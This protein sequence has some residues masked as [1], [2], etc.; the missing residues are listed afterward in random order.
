MDV[1]LI[2]KHWRKLSNSALFSSVPASTCSSWGGACPRN[3][4][5]VNQLDYLLRG[6]CWCNKGYMIVG[7]TINY[8]V[9]GHG[10]TL[11]VCPIM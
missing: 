2:E 5:L 6:V 8:V 9:E 3:P 10:S 4:V 7:T 11:S 1:P